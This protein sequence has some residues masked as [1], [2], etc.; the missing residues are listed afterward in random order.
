MNGHAQSESN[1]AMQSSYVLALH[2]FSRPTISSY[3]NCRYDTF[4]FYGA[5]K[6]K[7]MSY[8]AHLGAISKAFDKLDI[9]SSKKTHAMRGSGAR[10]TAANG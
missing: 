4:L 3:C 6:F 7:E 10:D 8:V 2:T 5:N 1:A 9:L